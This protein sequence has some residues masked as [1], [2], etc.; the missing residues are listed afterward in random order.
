ML[1]SRAWAPSRVTNDEIE[2]AKA[3]CAN[4]G[5]EPDQN[6]THAYG[7]DFTAREWEYRWALNTAI[8][9]QPVVSPMWRLSRARA[10]IELA[11]LQKVVES[12]GNI[13]PFRRRD[14]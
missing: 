2:K 13:V 7:D 1:H 9:V 12:S 14:G 3:L 5:L 8:P 11:C 6:V 4:D 10:V